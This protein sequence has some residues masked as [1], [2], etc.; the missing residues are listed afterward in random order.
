MHQAGWRHNQNRAIQSSS[1]LFGQNIGQTLDRFTQA[2]VVGE[3]AAKAG[4][5]QELQPAQ[6][7][8]LIVTKL[9][10]QADRFG[11]GF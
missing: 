5:P 10:A 1:L 4:F 8:T 7:L 2:H 3:D 9:R 6:A 11:Q